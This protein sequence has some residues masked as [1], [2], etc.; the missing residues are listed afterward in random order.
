MK[1]IEQIRIQP[2]LI[3][4]DI[5]PDGGRGWAQLSSS[6]KPQQAAIIF[7]WGGGWDHVSVSFKSRIPTWE[8]MAEVKRM[9]FRADETVIQ[10]HP[11]E[12]DYVNDHPNCL[13][14]W[15]NQD[16]DHELPPWWMTGRKPGTTKQDAIKAANA[17]FKERAEKLAARNAKQEVTL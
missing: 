13:H 2:R 4:R 8:E 15:R 5:G 11:R 9:F 7:S 12:E 6:R 1:T 17:H 10:F 3:I 14:L 16:A